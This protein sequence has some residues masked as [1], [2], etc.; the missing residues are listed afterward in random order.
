MNVDIVF[1]ETGADGLER[2]A[3]SAPDAVV[4]DI[5]LPGIDGWQVLAGLRQEPVTEHLPV[6][7]LTSHG[8]QYGVAQA[9]SSGAEGFMTKPF[10][11]NELRSAVSDLLNAA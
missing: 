4:L 6:L 9:L 2:A 11:P 1:A 10:L 3:D 7:M 5:A 8:E